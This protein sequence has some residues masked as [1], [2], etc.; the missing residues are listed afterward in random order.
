M[1]RFLWWSL[2]ILLSPVLLFV[3][4]AI[5]IYLPPAQNWLV[6]QV[7]GVASAET[8]MD[9]RVGRVSLSF[10][11][12]LAVNDA[13][14]I[15]QRD[16][17]AD[18]RRAVV[19]IQLLPLLSS[20][21]VV[22]QLEL[23]H[24]SV[25]TNG[26]VEAARVKGRLSRLSLTSRGVDLSR[27]T[28]EMNDARIE[29]AHIDI[30]LRDSVPEDT[31]TSETRW[32]I[33]ADNVRIERSEV[34][35]HMPGDSMSVKAR[36]GRLE[37]C[38]TLA[39]LASQTY[40]V[41]RAD[42]TDGGLSYD[43]NFLPAVSGL[44]V[45]HIS[46]ADVCVGVDSICFHDPTLRLSL[47]QL[48]F[49]EKSGLR[50]TGASGLV[51]MEDG[52]IRL[53]ALRVATPYSGAEIVLDL[54]LSLT[55]NSN[56]GRMSARL[57]ARLGKDDLLM[58]L[59]DLPDAF[60]QEWPGQPL[61]LECAASGNLRRLDLD[62]LRLSLPTAFGL[63]A[64]GFAANID[65]MASLRADIRLRAAT[66]NLDFVLALLP[67]DT[68]RDYRLPGGIHAE[69]SVRADGP[70]Y[71]TDM[72]L[73]EGQGEVS[74]K[75]HFNTDATRYMA[76]VRVRD[77]NIH[78]FMP[79]DSLYTASADIRAEGQGTDF[80]SPVTTLTADVAV[81]QLGYAQWSLDSVTARAE[82]CDGRAHADV[83]SHNRLLR[84][85][86]NLDALMSK[87]RI[88]ATCSADIGE[89]DLH[90][91]GL[92]R[93]PL[94]MGLCGHFDVRSDLRLTHYVSG[95][96]NDLTI[97]DS[98]KVYRPSDI[99]LL[100]NT[101]PDTTYLRLQSGDFIV[102]ADGSGSYE[103]LLRQC[104]ALSD[105]IAG[106]YAQKIIDQPALRRLLPVARLHIESKSDNP[107]VRLLKS[108]KNIDFQDMLADISSSPADGLNGKGHLH[109][110]S[111][112]DMLLDTINFRI[113]QRATHLS[114]GAQVR[115]N[116]KNP[117]F[118]FNALFDGVVQERGVTFGLR[119]F[120]AAD[121]LGA[122]IGA[123]AEMVDSGIS[124]HLIPERPT[125]GYKEFALNKDNFILLG[126][127]KKIL[128]KIDLIADDG[129]GVKIYSNDNDPTSLQ[130]ITLSLNSFNLRE[131]TSVI[132][133]MPRMTGHL[134]GDYHVVQDHSGQ[135]SLV[136]DMDVRDMTYE[137]SP[138]G[139]VSTEMVY[140]QKEGNAHAI[141]ARLM[142]DGREIG[143]VAGTYHN[144]GDGSLDA[145]LSLERL[146]LS[147]VNGFVPDHL[148]GL[149]G[150]GEGELTV[151]GQLSRPQV[152]GEVYL[153][154]SY[155]ESVPY[156]VTLRFDNDPVRIVDSNLLLENFT[157]YAHNDNPLNIQ[158]N[159]N[160]SNLDQVTVDMR[161]RA[162]NIQLIGMRESAKSIAYGKAFFDIYATMR[163]PVDDMSLRGRLNVLG[164]TDMGYILRDSP[165]S[166]DNQLENLVKFTD[167]GDTT[168]V[169]V[170]RP[171]LN[172]LRM[173]MTVDV[174]KGAHII[175]YLNADHSNYIDLMGGGTLRMQYTPS[176]NLR[177]T[178]RYTLSDGEMKYALPIIPLKTF[179]IKDGSYIEFTGDPANPTLN[180]TATE[181]VKA[182]VTGTSGVG[183]GVDFDCG[184]VITKTLSDMGLA[185]TL[186]APEDMQLHSELQSMGVEQR[187]KLA[188][189]MLTT[190]MYLADG[191]TKPFSMNSAL[192]SF[193]SSEISNL[194]GN[195][196]RTLDLSFG[197]DNS[198][199]A[200]GNTS[201]D[202]SFKFAKRFLNNRLKVAVGG[203][204][205]TGAEMP[206]RNKSFFDNVSLEYRLDDS[207]NKY[208]SLFYQNN[209]YDW[210]DGYT[211]KYGGGFIWRRT[212]QNFSD[213]FRLKEPAPQTRQ[214]P[215]AAPP[216]ATPAA[217]ASGA[218]PPSSSAAI[219]VASGSP[220]GAPKTNAHET[221]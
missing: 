40:T 119:Y 192:S 28:V 80:L 51:A 14:V 19:D 171:P 74:L 10:P 214:R 36:I 1:K 211:Q 127:N 218:A 64:G 110:L 181:R 106:Q 141:E 53:P 138:I 179:I 7:A 183:R 139:N 164:T 16:T 66:E 187:G 204:V 186:D 173:D 128:T 121:K 212:L 23:S 2:G 205:S 144:E 73:R 161:M 182:T 91:L 55:E 118:V 61:R 56:P 4:L 151:R 207:A 93:K 76:E 27:Q 44:D 77:L 97:R 114:L 50:L 102:K 167:F 122:R 92:V 86:V 101:R 32:K 17:I 58:L 60:R 62:S 41:K 215:A 37:V 196:L 70:T 95:L 52:S 168:Q 132:P 25:D 134:N 9:I 216:A 190:G 157:V 220:A 68:R 209:S 162:R 94:R 47:R 163:G 108:I 116:R 146:P 22:N 172:G 170:E 135:L 26:F 129:T 21:V 12:D 45:N 147:I 49:Q 54:P 8:G 137:N 221:K 48:A 178:G 30:A 202:Y 46:L 198:T 156:G 38:E 184:V 148:F 98:A 176:D 15:H 185:F 65:D 219:T 136:G 6:D 89:A 84:G 13:L 124:I 105:S 87:S 131:I 174:S 210:L 155:V 201:T 203:K 165:I 18:I 112:G 11:L 63:T 126:S 217:P 100:L 188:V 208:L 33:H 20:R 194:T 35:L 69:G 120:D 142:K 130:D 113:T 140:L 75:G 99:G 88:D 81:H 177:L 3:I 82:V 79:R 90:R 175:A 67:A 34:A 72:T 150:Y 115:N 123:Q 59:P 42:W 160:F 199:D 83:K 29:D 213:L 200:S 158:G 107:M 180:I 133:Y 111:T 43:Q 197:M 143:Q 152:N 78:H 57:K 96:V 159:V 109:A 145:R 103:Q 85:S 5:L 31:T 206:Q 153:D 117:Q 169:V 39:D 149:Q 24:A 166:T 193:L 195:A 104:A 189:S 71:S 125:L 154:S 191:N